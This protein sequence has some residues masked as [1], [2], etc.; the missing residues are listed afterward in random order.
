[1]SSMTIARFDPLGPEGKLQRLKDFTASVLETDQPIQRG[2][3]YID[4]IDH[5]FSAGVWDCTPFTTTLRPYPFNEF[6]LILEGS[7]TIV[8][9]GGRETVI[10]AGE[11]FIIPKGLNCQ[12]KQTGYLRKYYA[13][14]DGVPGQQPANCAALRVV[15]PDPEGDQQDVA[16][17]PAELLL[18]P[19]PVQHAREWFTDA[20][21]QLTVG[22]GI[23]RLTIANRFP[24]PATSYCMFLRGTLPSRMKAERLTALRRAILFWCHSGQS[25]TGSAASIREWSIALSDPRQKQKDTGGVNSFR[26]PRRVGSGMVAICANISFLVKTVRVSD[27]LVARN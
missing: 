6:M 26:G 18:T 5:G 21:G 2:H 10:H 8:E 9:P 16:P 4:D 1:M 19:A 3:L 7:V 23:R 14:F 27:T 25:V 11:T 15:R 22:P 17:P 12:W 13:I 20:T 24:F